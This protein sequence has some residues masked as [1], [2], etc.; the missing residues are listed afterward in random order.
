MVLL[1]SMLTYA[2]VFKYEKEIKKA[3]Q[4]KREKFTCEEGKPKEGAGG[5]ELISGN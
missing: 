5:G 2:D 4:E 3:K 1:F